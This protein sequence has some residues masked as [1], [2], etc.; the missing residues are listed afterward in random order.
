MI[1]QSAHCHCLVVRP[2]QKRLR[3]LLPPTLDK[4]EIDTEVGTNA[5]DVELCLRAFTGSSFLNADH[6]LHNATKGSLS[7][8]MARVAW[9]FP[10][11]N[12][13]LNPLFQ[14]EYA[15]RHHQP[16]EHDAVT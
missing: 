10:A 7:I 12:F 3:W 1:V 6:G 9:F 15:P 5:G 2:W 14:G 16:G 4:H 13:L 8:T 11:S